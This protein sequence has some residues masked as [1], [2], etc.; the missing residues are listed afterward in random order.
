MITYGSD[1]TKNAALDIH[2]PWGNYWLQ[3]IDQH[4][5]RGKTKHNMSD[6]GNGPVYILYSKRL[7]LPTNDGK[8]D[9]FK[10]WYQVGRFS[11]L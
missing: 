3:V 1:G 7:L 6:P 2:R 9:L 10:P 11:S 8:N 4:G 5:L